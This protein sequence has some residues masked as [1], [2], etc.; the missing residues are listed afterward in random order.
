[1]SGIEGGGGGGGAQRN[2][3]RGGGRAGE[4][5]PGLYCTISLRST[6]ETLALSRNDNKIVDRVVKSQNI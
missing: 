2:R 1:M 6:K 5:P 3:P 4:N